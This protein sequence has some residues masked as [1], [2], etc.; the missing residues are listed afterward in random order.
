MISETHD[1]EV[2]VEGEER[3]IYRVKVDV[4]VKGTRSLEMKKVS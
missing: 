4:K 3:P 2:K 1:L